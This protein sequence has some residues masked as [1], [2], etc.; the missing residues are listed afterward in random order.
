[1]RI[2]I[3][4]QRQDSEVIAEQFSIAGSDHA[5]GV[6]HTTIENIDRGDFEFSA[7]HVATGMRIA[8]GK[9]IDACIT[10]ARL[11]W[12]SKTPEELEASIAKA[13]ALKK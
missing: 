8:Q 6:H 5:F 7:T 1:M 10:A 3:S 2:M 11:A 4:R 9:T 12:Q 13:M